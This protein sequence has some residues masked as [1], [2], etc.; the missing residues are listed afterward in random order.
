MDRP[1]SR[2]RS[3]RSSAAG[4]GFKRA[5][6]ELLAGFLGYGV[7]QEA[8][9]LSRKPSSSEY[10]SNL[11]KE[12]CTGQTDFLEEHRMSRVVVGALQA[13]FL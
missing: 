8:D 13:P 1:L 9:Q 11:H 3:S 2:F 10:C 6:P 4:R 12:T 7:G 5:S